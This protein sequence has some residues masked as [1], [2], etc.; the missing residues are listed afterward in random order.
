MVILCLNHIYFPVSECKYFLFTC[1]QEK[2][3]LDWGQK[4]KSKWLSPLI[5]G[6]G[7]SFD[8]RHRMKFTAKYR[9]SSSACPMLC[10][11]SCILRVQLQ[12]L[13]GWIF[14]S[15]TF[16]SSPTSCLSSSPD[17][18]ST[19]I[20][21]PHQLP[22]EGGTPEA[23]V[24]SCS[25]RAEQELCWQDGTQHTPAA[26]SARKTKIPLCIQSTG[27]FPNGKSGGC[28]LCIAFWKF[29][30][31]GDTAVWLCI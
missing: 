11:R 1:Q 5:S 12:Q 3:W 27:A 31:K 24:P 14:S 2:T 15:A 4:R 19:F 10:E 29:V 13:S 25:Q 22:R 28:W 20:V 9:F 26:L 18:E 7:T 6:E 16:D 23:T 17:G 21:C 8:L 30:P